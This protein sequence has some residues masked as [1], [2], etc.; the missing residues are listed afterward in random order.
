MKKRVL[1]AVIAVC[2]M[3][4]IAGCSEQETDVENV[5]QVQTS[6]T[7]ESQPDESVSDT[8]TTTTTTTSET[9]TTTAS[10]EAETQR[11][12]SDDGEFKSVNYEQ[13]FN[14]CEKCTALL[15]KRF[16]YE[17]LIDRIYKEYKTLS[18]SEFNS[19]QTKTYQLFKELS[20]GMNHDCSA[21]TEFVN[22]YP[23]AI[24]TSKGLYTGYWKGSGPV[25]NGKYIG[26]PL[27]AS[28]SG[29]TI[30]YSYSYKGNWKNGLP[31]GYGDQTSDMTVDY[32]NYTIAYTLRYKGGMK[33]AFRN[34]RGTIYYI[35]DVQVS[36]DQSE[37]LY[38]YFDEATFTNNLLQQEINY[39]AYDGSGNMFQTGTAKSDAAFSAERFPDYPAMPNMVPVYNIDNEA[40]DTLQTQTEQVTQNTQR[41]T[42]T[43]RTT[44]TKKPAVTTKKAATGNNKNTVSKNSSKG[45]ELLKKGAIVLGA[46]GAT[47]FSIKALTNSI[48]NDKAEFEKWSKDSAEQS[49]K[50]IEDSLQKAEKER[51]KAA[52]QA[53]QFQAEQKSGWNWSE[54][55][56]G[57]REGKDKN[58]PEMQ[59]YYRNGRIPN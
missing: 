6:A 52:Q 36:P 26:I 53:E 54:Y 15:K 8:T 19:I 14:S 17:E 7:V 10:T 50:N 28:Q 40:D 49:R 12:A 38:Y 55:K 56:K 16:E 43:Q 21:K 5:S 2:M 35:Y 22:N 13:V 44:T 59:E 46:V 32:G 45:K 42:V 57:L 31:D 27:D 4:S 11:R 29:L 34:G 18:Q 51:E 58:S 23:Y 25:G 24:G 9:T 39:Y 30:D 33:E 47:Y 37:K 1:S 48:K 20:S 41:Q 3:I